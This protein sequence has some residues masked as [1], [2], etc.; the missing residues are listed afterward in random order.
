VII[1]LVTERMPRRFRANFAVSD[2]SAVEVDSPV[3]RTT[4]SLVSVLALLPR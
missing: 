2:F 1:S 4:P 3:T